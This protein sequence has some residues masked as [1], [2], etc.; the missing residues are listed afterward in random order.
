MK[1]AN[2]ALAEVAKG[3]AL[4]VSADQLAQ[5]RELLQRYLPGVEVRA[6]GSRA[7]GN[8]KP[9]SDLDLMVFSG[10]PLDSRR[11]ALLTDAFAE[12]DLPFKVDIVDANTVPPSFRARALAE[13]LVVQHGVSSGV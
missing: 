10:Q 5:V 9:A 3:H 4:V 11:H 13:S 7:R 12:S 8:P 1:P 6:F 2:P